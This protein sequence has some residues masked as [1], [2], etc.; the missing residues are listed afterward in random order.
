MDNI[1]SRIRKKY[2]LSRIA[3]SKALGFGVNQWRKYE[4]ENIEPNDTHTFMIS[5]AQ[6]PKS[7]R[8]LLL[9]NEGVLNREL[10]NKQ[11]VRLLG[12]VDKIL[13]DFRKVED[14]SYKEWAEQLFN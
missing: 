1:Y 5:V 11:F 14:A 9:K 8:K 6:D 7:F 2:G 13:E 12:M 10:G 4:D 3:M